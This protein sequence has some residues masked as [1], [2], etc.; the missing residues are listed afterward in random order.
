MKRFMELIV[1][2]KF[3]WGLIFSATILLY[4]VVAM[5]YG[6]TAMDFILIWQL[7]GITLVLGVIHLL[8]Y[9]EFILRSLNTKY[10][11]VIHFIACYIVC[12]VS[13][14]ILKWV[15]I[16]NIKEV[17]VFS[18]V[19]IVIYLSLFLSLYMYYKF[20]GEQLNDRLAAYKQNK[21]L[22]GGEKWP[23]LKSII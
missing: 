17:L 13:V 5:L 4:S 20:T 12:F 19:Y 16:L 2:F 7:V 8:I 6:E 9:G 3:V 1:Q 10:K 14:D 21:K 15:D 22:E 23:L 18:G 11:A